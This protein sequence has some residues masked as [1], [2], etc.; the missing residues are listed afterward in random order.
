MNFSEI[1]EM[2][3]DTKEKLKKVF[4]TAI[5]IAKNEFSVDFSIENFYCGNAKGAESW[6]SEVESVTIRISDHTKPVSMFYMGDN[7]T[8]DIEILYGN[9]FK[10]YDVRVKLTVE[11]QK[12]INEKMRNFIQKMGKT[13]SFK[14]L[15]SQGKLKNY[16]EKDQ[17]ELFLLKNFQPYTNPHSKRK[18]F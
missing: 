17:L 3:K 6:Y 2:Q 8:H 10:A 15:C 4:E 7:S 12:L 11:K 16:K 13:Q 18:I 1:L 9:D 14:N 5:E